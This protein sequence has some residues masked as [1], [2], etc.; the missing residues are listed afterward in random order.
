LSKLC[1][2]N[3]GQNING[4]DITSWGKLGDINRIGNHM[5]S[6]SRPEI[7]SSK[8]TSMELDLSGDLIIKFD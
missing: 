5:A 7:C 1:I 8:P 3:R 4:N 6:S 2:L